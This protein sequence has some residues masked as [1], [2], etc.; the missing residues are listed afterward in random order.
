MHCTRQDTDNTSDYIIDKTVYYTADSKGIFHRIIYIQTNNPK[1]HYAKREK[2][3]E[4]MHYA[5]C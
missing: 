5:Y 4:I 2:I 3:V 1:N